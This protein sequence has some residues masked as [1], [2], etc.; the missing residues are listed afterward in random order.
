LELATIEPVADATED[1]KKL[2]GR[3]PHIKNTGKFSC[4]LPPGIMIVNTTV[5][6]KVIKS[7][8]NIDHRIP[9]AEFLYRTLRSRRTRF[10]SSSRY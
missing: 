7:G 4:W 10:L 8:F 3:N 6:T 2:H 9:R 5:N 1:E